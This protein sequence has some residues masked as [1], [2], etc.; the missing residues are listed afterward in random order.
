MVA[1]GHW[2]SLNSCDSFIVVSQDLIKASELLIV[3]EEKEKGGE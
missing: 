3:R 1:F 2:E